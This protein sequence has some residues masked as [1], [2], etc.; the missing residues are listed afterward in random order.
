MSLSKCTNPFKNTYRRCYPES[1]KDDYCTRL[2][3]NIDSSNLDVGPNLL[4]NWVLL[5]IKDAEEQTFLMRKVSNKQA[6]RILNPW[7]TSEILKQQQIRDKL[8]KQW[9]KS[10]KI[11]NSPLH[12]LQKN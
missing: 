5:S 6:K 2:K 11:A 8:K 3:H 1:K 10:G 7:M 4:L 9:I 12:K